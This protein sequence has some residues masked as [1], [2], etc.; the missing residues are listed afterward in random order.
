MTIG[1]RIR[2]ERDA[3]GWSRDALAKAC[4]ITART[5]WQYESGATSP[6]IDTLQLIAAE[7]GTTVAQL[8]DEA[9]AELTKQERAVLAALRNNRE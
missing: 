7:L 2:Q 3:F 9:P 5:L 8:I 6:K 4:G 1:Q